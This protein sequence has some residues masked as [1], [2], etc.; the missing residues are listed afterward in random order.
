MTKVIALFLLA[1][2]ILVFGSIIDSLLLKLRIWLKNRKEQ[3]QL[4]VDVCEI[5]D[6][7]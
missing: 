4:A 3:K 2:F 7:K 6:E 1:L 5:M